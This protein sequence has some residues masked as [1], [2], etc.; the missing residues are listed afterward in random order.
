MQELVKIFR[1]RELL[2]G[3]RCME[4]LSGT[5][6]SIVFQNNAG[7]FVVFRLV[8]VNEANVVSVVGNIPQPLVGEELE[9]SGEWVEHSRFG[10]QFKAVT[11]QRVALPSGVKGIERFLASGAIK[12]IG[13]AM[14]ARLVQ[15][16]GV[17]ALEVIEL[18]PHRL[19]EVVGIGTK[20]AAIIRMSYSEHSEM[21]DIM[22]FLET[23]GVSGAY[24]RKIYAHYG[25]TAINVLN[26]NPYR[27]AKEVP[28]IGFRIA[29]HIARTLGW[30]LNH[31]DRISE[32]VR[33]ALLQTAQ[34]G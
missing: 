15:H 6:D 32:G 29:D 19:T 20:K 12:G 26:D 17:R 4:K 25:A 23:H 10:R 14:A 33:F 18:Y 1:I 16:F 24:A 21:R 31:P 9:L 34:G 13:P 28:G 7:S 3:G 27:L 8:P 2:F 11:Y 30:E 22:L 5:V